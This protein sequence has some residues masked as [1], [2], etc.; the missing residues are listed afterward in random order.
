MP[1]LGTHWRPKKRSLGGYRL[2][3]AVVVVVRRCLGAGDLSE[4]VGSV[5][6][7]PLSVLGSSVPRKGCV[8]AEERH[9]R[10]GGGW[11]EGKWWVNAGDLA[12]PI[13]VVRDEVKSRCFL[14]E[15]LRVHQPLIHFC[16]VW[17]PRRKCVH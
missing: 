3:I 6:N 10:Q 17:V 13:I 16:L 12:L 14:P 5:E 2:H 4:R 8:E 1:Y 11:G 9:V 15:A 7:P